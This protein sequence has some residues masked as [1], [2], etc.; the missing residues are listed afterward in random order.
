MTSDPA[1]LITD[2]QGSYALQFRTL[3]G[4]FLSLSGLLQ[5]WAGPTDRLHP[6]N[7]S[8]EELRGLGD[9]ITQKLT[10]CRVRKT[11]EKNPDIPVSNQDILIEDTSNWGTMIGF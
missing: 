9:T 4:P 5:E 7:T 8:E 2:I 11:G 1:W 3:I 6:R 10:I